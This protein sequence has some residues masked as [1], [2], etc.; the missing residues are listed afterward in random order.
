MSCWVH[1]ANVVVQV[2]FHKAGD[3]EPGFVCRPLGGQLASEEWRVFLCVCLGGVRCAASLH[4][5]CL[6]LSA[7]LSSSKGV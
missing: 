2:N 7:L 4:G 1:L 3:L 6:L 5:S